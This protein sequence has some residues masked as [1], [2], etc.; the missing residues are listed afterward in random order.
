MSTYISCYMGNP[1]K[2]GTD[3]T[4]ISEGG[5]QTSPLS[6]VLNSANNETKYV[7]CAIRTVSGFRTMGSTTLS[8]VTKLEDG[9]Y[10]TTGGTVDKWK[11]CAD[12]ETGYTEDEVKALADTS[13]SNSLVI[14]DVISATNVIFWVK[15]SSSEDETPATYT[16]VSIKKECVI[17]ADA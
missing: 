14:S 2:G 10:A 12:S 3:G 4:V 16:D 13:W 17:E 7:K 9:T 6:V 15:I 11:I 1:T 8:F 5:V